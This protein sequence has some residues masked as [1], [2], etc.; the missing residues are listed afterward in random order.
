[1][2]LPLKRVLLILITLTTTCL[3]TSVMQPFAEAAE[4]KQVTT[5][6]TL[7][8]RGPHSYV[9]GTAYRDWTVDVQQ[10][11][12]QGYRW[13]RVFGDLNMC[14][15]VF[16]DA[17]AGNGSV[18]ESCDSA[19]RIMPDSQFSSAIGGGADDGADVA[20]SADPAACPTH[21]GAHI[22]GFGNVRPWQDATQAS[23][24]VNT[25]VGLGETVKWR[26]VS[27]DGQW[28]MVRAPQ[29][30]STDGT[31]LQPWF[32]LPRSCVPV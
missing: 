6:H 29:H 25:L 22:I 28:V 21:D 17:V 15:W 13:G 16:Q 8:R 32:F 9:L 11:A 10:E 14:L 12:L 20:V 7:L 2:R 4:R 30:G 18:A 23:S 1:V 27:R 5:D 24:P 3:V 26:Y 19:N 31:G